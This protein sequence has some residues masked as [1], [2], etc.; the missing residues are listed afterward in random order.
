MRTLY[1]L[2][3][4]DRRASFS[5]IEQSYRHSLNAHIGKRGLPLARK[6]QLRLQQ[7]RQAYLLL[8]SPILRMEYDLQLNRLERERLRKI[9]RVCT[10]IGLVLLV[11]GLTLIG[12]GYYRMQYGLPETPAVSQQRPDTMLA[13]KDA[14][15]RFPGKK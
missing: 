11:V 10:R 1:D 15:P 12:R 13:I 14:L 9:E 4:V 8:S 5:D 2:L 3:G 7:M 6:E